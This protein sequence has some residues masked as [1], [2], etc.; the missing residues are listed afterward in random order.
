MVDMADHR[1]L[2]AVGRSPTPMTITWPWIVVECPQIIGGPMTSP[3]E[4][5]ALVTR[6]EAVLKRLETGNTE[7]PG[8]CA[9]CLQD[10]TVAGHLPS[11]Y[12]ARALEEVVVWEARTDAS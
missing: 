6:L 8:A 3:D 5:A 7:F 1:V 2:R 4:T 10:V 11:C 12:L 9:A